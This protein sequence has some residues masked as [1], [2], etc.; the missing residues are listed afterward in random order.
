MKTMP[1]PMLGIILLMVL[2]L[3]A[4]QLNEFQDIDGFEYE[5]EYAIPLVDASLSIQDLLD[6]S[7]SDLTFLTIENDGSFT[8]SYQDST[9]ILDGEEAL[10]SFP[11]SFPVPVPNQQ[12]IFEFSQIDEINITS[13]KLKTGTLDFEISSNIAEDLDLTITF[14]G[15]TKDGQ[16]LE[17]TTNVDYQGSLPVEANIAAVDLTGYSIVTQNGDLQVNYQALDASNQSRDVAVILG[18]ADN[19]TFENIIGEFSQQNFVLET[20]TIEIDLY[21]NQVE[22][23]LFFSDPRLKIS[24][25]NSF[26]VGIA[27]KFMQISVL[28]TDDQVI[29][30]TGNLIDDGFL[31]DGPGINQQGETVSREYII[32]RTNSNI[33]VIFNSEPKKIWYTLELEAAPGMGLSDG[34]VLDESEVTVGLSFELPI[35]GRAKGF[36]TE[37]IVDIDLG[38]EDGEILKEA[39]LKIITANTIP[40]DVGIQVYLLNSGGLTVDSLFAD[41]ETLIR[42]NASSMT[43]FIDLTPSRLANLRQSNKIKVRSNFSTQDNGA[44]NVIIKND[45]TL[46]L[47]MG[48]RATLVQ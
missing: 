29:P 2:F 34:F 44:T 33:D 35:E 46:D 11:S 27:V 24:V 47:K 28:T 10:K 40:I 38:T 31:V 42:A 20:D 30:L 45:Q 14:P 39:Q 15:L 7:E 37:N 19:W 4:C 13:A 17:L 16:A 25:N 18:N 22:G 26:G 6:R 8:L 36:S 43:S 48:L 9:K 3:P 5:A 1:I 32:D 41:P 23:E 21:N 12:T